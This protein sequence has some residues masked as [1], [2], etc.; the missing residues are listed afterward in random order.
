M[1]ENSSIAWT[2]HT[3][4]FVIGCTKVDELCTN[5][6]ADTM[7]ERRFS[8]TL[9][10]G[11]KDNPV[12]HWGPHASRYLR[13]GN[14]KEEL[15]TLER[16]ARKAGR[17][18]KVFINSLS[19]TFED[20]GDLE[21]ARVVLFETILKCPNLIFQLLTKR[22]ENVRRCV[23]GGWWNNWPSNAWI[24]TSVGHQKSADTRIPELLKIPAKTRFLSCEPLLDKV[25]LS[26]ALRLEHRSHKKGNGPWIDDGWHPGEES[27]FFV[28]EKLHWVIVG[29]E[30]GDRVRVM[31][32]AWARQLF[33][34]CKAAR[35]PFF[36][37]QDSARLPGQRG[38]IP[39]DLWVQEFP[40]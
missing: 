37:K 17:I 24:G 18:D 21:T 28:R 38:R 10:G 20:R 7:D 39:D 13:I 11:T 25:D 30:S 26:A 34:Q 9:D 4:N 29:G 40:V 32:I 8:K 36:M 2:N 3:V 22:P 15:L 35:V 6:Y 31:D 23:S 16:K 14:A 12:R 5:C 1:A 27:K 19:D 33:D